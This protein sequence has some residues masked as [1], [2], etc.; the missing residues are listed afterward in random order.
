MRSV[1]KIYK[2]IDIEE[3][4]NLSEPLSLFH[5]HR[6]RFSLLFKVFNKRCK[7]PDLHTKWCNITRMLAHL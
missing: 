4:A 1:L 7:E 5:C 2:Y 3:I 6:L